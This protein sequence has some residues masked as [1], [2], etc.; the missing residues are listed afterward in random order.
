MNNIVLLAGSLTGL[1]GEIKSLR[2]PPDC[3]VFHCY[4]KFARSNV[5]SS[6]ESPSH[7]SDF[8]DLGE[9]FLTE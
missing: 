3:G 4:H 2:R 5:G 8:I 7:A 9:I 1:P 6:I